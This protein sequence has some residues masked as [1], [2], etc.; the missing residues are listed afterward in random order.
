MSQRELG[1][2]SGTVH[3]EV[4][5]DATPVVVPPRRVPM[6][7]EKK[8]KTELDSLQQ[9]EVIASMKEPTPWASSLV[10]TPGHLTLP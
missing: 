1:A 7:L 6:S 2:L 9:L 5:Q 8:L 10:S 4:E 3:L